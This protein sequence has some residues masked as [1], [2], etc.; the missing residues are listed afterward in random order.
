MRNIFK[1]ILALVFLI[2]CSCGFSQRTKA[3][4]GMLGADFKLEDVSGQTVTLADYRGKQDVILLFWASWCAFCR[5][6]LKSLGARSEELKKNDI[7]I[8]AINVE[9][10]KKV[11]ERFLSRYKIDLKA[12]LDKDGTVAN[13]YEVVGIPTYVWIDKEGHIE[14]QGHSFPDIE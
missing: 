5:K 3:E 12:L 8:L 7:E 13:N 11:V 10:S 1:V 2:S 4:E 9:E 14:Y 6:E